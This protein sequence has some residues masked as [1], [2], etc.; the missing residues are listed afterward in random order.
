MRRL[1]EI[2]QPIL[3]AYVL[4]MLVLVAGFGWWAPVKGIT[5]PWIPI[6][7]ILIT[8]FGISTS[9]TF[10]RDPT[11]QIPLHPKLAGLSTDRFH[12]SS[13]LSYWPLCGLVLWY[14]V[15][16]GMTLAYVTGGILA[17]SALIWKVA[18]L[19]ALKDW[20]SIAARIAARLTQ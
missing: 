17:A 4:L 16:H 3:C 19:G 7:F 14:M 12:L 2:L 1:I 11:W 18:K 20:K 10:Y 5:P 8:V 13:F 6:S 15:E 9:H